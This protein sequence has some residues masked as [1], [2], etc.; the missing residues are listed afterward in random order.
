MIFWIASYPRSGNTLLRILLKEVLGYGTFE[1]EVFDYSLLPGFFETIDPKHAQAPW[2]E[3]I[4][5]AQSTTEPVFIKTHKV[6]TDGNPVI[7]IFRD[8]RLCLESYLRF[9]HDVLKS[10]DASLKRLIIGDDYYGCWSDFCAS[11]LAEKMERTLVLKYEE[12]VEN[13]DETLHLIAKFT[14]LPAPQKKWTNPFV[15]LNEAIPNFFRNGQVRWHSDEDSWQKSDRTA[16]AF[17]HGEMM[18]RLGYFAAGEREAVLVDAD[19]DFCE[20][21]HLAHKQCLTKFRMQSDL[22]AKEA[23]IQELLRVKVTPA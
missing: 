1:S 6:P 3:F 11:A 10:S 20:Y 2:P 22:E 12:V 16:F 13:T 8:G 9:H 19:H 14:G 15:Q 17:L 21:V 18:E 7:F 23:V 4:A 5:W